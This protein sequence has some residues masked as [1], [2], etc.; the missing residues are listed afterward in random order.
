MERERERE[1]ERV[2]EGQRRGDGGEWT[3]IFKEMQQ[4]VTNIV[5]CLFFVVAQLL[6][7]NHQQL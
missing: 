6:T 5:V 1:R 2:D 3:M 4:Q 7:R